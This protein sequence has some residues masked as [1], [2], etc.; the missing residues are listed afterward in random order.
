MRR[1]QIIAT[2]L[3][4]ITV[5]ACEAD[6][7]M[8]PQS[9][10]MD[11]AAQLDLIKDAVNELP[12]GDISQ[13]VIDGLILMREEEKLARDVYQ[14]FYDLYSTN[15]FRNIARSEARHMSAIKTLLDKY[16]IADPVTDD[17]RGVFTDPHMT[18]LYSQLTTAGEKSLLDAMIVGATIEDLDIKD[19]M[20]LSEDVEAEDIL[21]VYRNL[22]KGSRNH[23]RAFHSQ[24]ERNNGSYTP[25]YI[26]Q[27]LYDDIISSPRER[28][29]A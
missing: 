5:T 1:I 2:L 20:E 28:G 17:T 9:P 19:L 15:V 27:E 6:N 23:M 3:L 29:R 12:A 10:V 24:I 26:S 14:H 11:E 4:F 7:G 16:G 8:G 25:Q 21:M 13:E 22:T 18:D